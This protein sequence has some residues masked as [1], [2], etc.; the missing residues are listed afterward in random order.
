MEN[1]STLIQSSEKVVAV[2]ECGLDYDRLDF[3]PKIT[4]LELIL[5]SDELMERFFKSQLQLAERHKLPLFLHNRNSAT[6]LIQI[7][8]EN[9]SKLFGGVVHS[10]DG[11]IEQATEIIDLGFHIGINGCSL[12]TTANLECVKLIPCEYIN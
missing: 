8:R 2:G 3:C 12:K 7:L 9:K 1:L 11:T 6:D 4:Q 10:F 5:L